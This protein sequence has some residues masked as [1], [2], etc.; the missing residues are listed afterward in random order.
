KVLALAVSARTSTTVAVSH[1]PGRGAGP[2]WSVTLVALLEPRV[3]VVVVAVAFPEPRLVVILE[4][5]AGDPFRAL[6]EV[7]V[8][9]QQPGRAPVLDRQGVSLVVP[10]N[11]RLA[12]GHVL[13]REVRRVARVA[14]GE[15]VRCGGHRASHREEG[16]DRHAAEFDAELGP[17]GD[18]VDVPLEGRG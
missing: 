2:G 5:Q 8:R 18:A 14:Q 15:D 10:D 6:P 3:A 13:Q 7:Q 12:A 1:F 4:L 16:V 11:P 9:H 17:R